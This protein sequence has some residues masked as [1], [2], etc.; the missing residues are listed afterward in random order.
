MTIRDLGVE[1]LLSADTKP[2]RAV[3]S[4]LIQQIRDAP[5]GKYVRTEHPSLAPPPPIVEPT[6]AERV[7]MADLCADTKKYPDSPSEIPSSPPI[8]VPPTIQ[9]VVDEFADVF[10][11][12]PKGLH[13]YTAQM[14]RIQLVEGAQPPSHRIYRMAPAEEKELKEQLANYISLG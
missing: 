9:V 10:Q 1:H 3:L 12:L 7:K 4:P 8:P 11:P 14:H 5:D 2:P 13:Q 6:V